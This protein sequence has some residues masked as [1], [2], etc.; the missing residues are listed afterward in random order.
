MCTSGQHHHLRS[1]LQLPQTGSS[2]FCAKQKHQS[3]LLPLRVPNGKI[4]EEHT[5]NLMKFDALGTLPITLQLDR[6][7]EGQGIEAAMVANE[8]KWHQACKLR[9]NNTMLQRAEKR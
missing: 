6:I 9:F 2:V 1:Q 3:P 7:N 4:L 8:A 5:E